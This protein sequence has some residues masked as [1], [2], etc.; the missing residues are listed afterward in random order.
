MNLKHASTG[1]AILLV[2]T[3]WAP[4]RSVPGQ[5]IQSLSIDIVAPT[6]AAGKRYL[7]HEEKF[8]IRFSNSSNDPLLLWDED[9]RFGYGA[10]RFEVKVDGESHTVH[11]REVP[12][13]VW[14]NFPPETVIVPGKGSFSRKVSL[15]GFFWGEREWISP[16]EPN[17]GKDVEIK[18]KFEMTSTSD[19]LNEG[20][21]LGRVESSV[22][23]LPVVNPKLKI[24]QDYLWNC[25]PRQAL[26]L[27][28]DDPAWINKPE[29]EYQCAPLHHAARFGYK[30]VVTWLIENEA[31]V[32][33]VA[34]NGFTPLHLTEKKEIADILIKA[35]ANLNQKDNYGK[36]PLLNALETRKIEVVEAIMDSGFKPNLYTTLVLDRRDLALKMLM[37][38]TNLVVGGEGGGDLGRNTTPLG[39]AA[40]HGDIELAKLLLEA[41][42]PVDDGTDCFRFGGTATPLCNAVWA[43]KTEMVEFLLKKGAVT[44]VV[45]GKFVR[46]LTEYAEKYSDRRTLELLR[47]YGGKGNL[48]N[49][50]QRTPQQNLLPD[51]IASG[52][53]KIP[54][55]KA[56]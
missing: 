8:E 52:E 20:V 31:N 55:E 47:Q 35:G 40:E 30:E 44:N 37:E 41:G 23:T 12:T 43:G 26:K 27:L 36:T 42:A 10:L 2:L 38:D 13:H 3:L 25:C 56:K 7:P 18:A 17:T 22:L 46:S 33:A 50:W 9:C 49:R 6:N 14:T 32:N 48:E 54:S 4:C 24:P 53:F 15:T 16:P 29:P 1:T 34:Y 51:R 5:A 21:W 19:S 39:W 28:K 11:R 45:G